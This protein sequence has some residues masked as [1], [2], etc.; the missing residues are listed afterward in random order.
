MGLTCDALRMRYR[1]ELIV[2]KAYESSYWITL[3]HVALKE[4]IKKEKNKRIG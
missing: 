3:K 1:E 4:D 2:L